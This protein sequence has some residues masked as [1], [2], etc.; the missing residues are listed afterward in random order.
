MFQ[1]GVIFMCVG[2]IVNALK[3]ANDQ[4]KEDKIGKFSGLSTR[5]V[6]DSSKPRVSVVQ[7]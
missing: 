4:K 2:T 6:D 1:S 3:L 7:S 5:C